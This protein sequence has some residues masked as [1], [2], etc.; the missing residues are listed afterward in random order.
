MYVAELSDVVDH[1][2]EFVKTKS[3]V[4]IISMTVGLSLCRYQQ[5]VECF[6]KAQFASQLKRMQ[7]DPGVRDLASKFM[8][9]LY[10]R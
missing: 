4:M 3:N 5:C 7:K 2:V 1:I 10:T 8:S 9:Y 6:R